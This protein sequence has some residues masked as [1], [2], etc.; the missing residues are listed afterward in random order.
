MEVVPTVMRSIIKEVRKHRPSSLSI[1][2]F[3]VLAFLRHH[4]G[5]SLSELAEHVGLTLPTMSK[6]VDILVKRGYVLREDSLADRRRVMLNLSDLGLDTFMTAHQGAE[7]RVAQTLAPLSPLQ[8]AQV[9]ET[10]NALRDVFNPEA[11][12]VRPAA[13]HDNL[14]SKE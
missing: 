13:D 6:V 10:M 8:K 9:S 1:A 11:A 4:P 3:R 7:L 14:V 5:T 2:Q 12:S